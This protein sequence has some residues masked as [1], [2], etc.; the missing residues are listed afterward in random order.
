MARFITS[1][2]SMPTENRRESGRQEAA[3]CTEGSTSWVAI[4]TR[5]ICTRLMADVNVSLPCQ[6]GRDTPQSSG[7]VLQLRGTDAAFSPWDLYSFCRNKHE[8]TDHM[9]LFKCQISM[10]FFF[11]SLQA[12][13]GRVSTFGGSRSRGFPLV[14]LLQ[15]YCSSHVTLGKRAKEP[16]SLFIIFLTS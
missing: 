6:P 2:H 10:Y 8:V 14:T 4:M 1:C 13:T 15:Q 5:Q 9:L 11:F 12:E 16:I 7:T 3:F